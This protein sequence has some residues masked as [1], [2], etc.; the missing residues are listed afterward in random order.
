MPFVRISI[1]AGSAAA[2]AALA[3]AVHQALVD[4]FSVPPDDRFQV[5]EE[6]GPGALVCTPSYLG[7]RHERPAFVQIV[8]SVGRDLAQKRALFARIAALGAE[9]A[10]WRREDLIVHLVEVQK[11]NWSF[12]N[13]LA[14]YA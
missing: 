13:G 11:E 2:G 12:G 14:Q 5:V 4:T 7:V 6:L 3:D 8:C 1:P 10:G 9:R